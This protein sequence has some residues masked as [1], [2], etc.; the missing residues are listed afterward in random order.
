MQQKKTY[1][2]VLNIIACFCVVMMHVNQMEAAFTLDA[3]GKSRVMIDGL[4]YFAVPVFFMISGA[5]L[6]DY[7]Q[8]Y[9]TGV[10]FKKR[11]EKVAVPFLFWSVCGMVYCL[12]MTDMTGRS[13][14]SLLLGIVN[15]EYVG[16][17]WFFIPLFM[18]YLTMPLFSA[19]EPKREIFGYLIVA[20]LLL[21]I[22]LPWIADRHWV[23]YNELLRMPAVG[24]YVIF[25]LLGYYLD[26]YTL[27]LPL[28]ILMYALGIYGLWYLTVGTWQASEE[29]GML[30]TAYKGYTNLPAVFFASA[31]FL[32]VRQAAARIR[33]RR[34]LS[35]S[36]P[37]ASEAGAGGKASSAT[38]QSVGVRLVE[39]LSGVT[40]G[41][42]LIHRALLE[43][44]YLWTE[45][46]TD[47]LGYRLLGSVVIF[48]AS[49][50][51]VKL[52][53]QIPL[54]RRFVP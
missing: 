10:F 26:R 24:G 34:E 30:V 22:L 16:V 45:I 42:Y 31:V 27:P 35:E 15:A 44:V 3:V 14:G 18:V 37:E 19:V 5:N 33:A 1:L 12:L 41:I 49:G 43:L 13:A 46:N 21:N 7:R 28:R 4:C 54:I 50:L 29:W 39:Q 40:F 48:L 38:R 25:M 20:G 2:S 47:T 9:S 51:L 17:Y 32:A 11:F 23:G 8:R 6:L 53:Q 36:M 52:L